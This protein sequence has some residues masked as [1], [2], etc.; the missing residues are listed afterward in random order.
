MTVLV[1]AVSG[2]SGTGKTT[3]CRALYKLLSSSS[4]QN[5]SRAA[6]ESWPQVR[7]LHQDDFYLPE[8]ELPIKHIAHPGSAQPEPVVNWDCPAAL[9]LRAMRRVLQD[10]RSRA[11]GSF[12]PAVAQELAHRAKEGR[13]AIDDAI[14][15][16][17]A[18]LRQVGEQLQEAVEGRLDGLLIVDGFM[19]H[20]ST[21]SAETGADASSQP[22]MADLF[23][24]RV[25]LRAN[26]GG[27]VLRRRRESRTYA[28]LEGTWSDPPGYWDDIIWPEY[29]AHHRY[30]F[31]DGDVDGVARKT[32]DTGVLVQSGADLLDDGLRFVADALIKALHR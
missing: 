15:I 5:L 6:P 20:H 23:D 8:R 27:E 29:V 9:D 17:D 31:Q 25:L 22:V 30:L 3:V 1:L 21:S 12:S 4:T 32:D 13:N 10:Y 18:T 11:D 7:L 26:G 16:D 24:V 28:T 2:A 19:L 14:A